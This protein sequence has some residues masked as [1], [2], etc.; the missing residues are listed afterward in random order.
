MDNLTLWRMCDELTVIQAARL[1]HGLHPTVS[2]GG[3]EDWS[4]AMIALVNAIRGGRLPATIRYSSHQ[5][6]YSEK[7]FQKQT[8]WQDQARLACVIPPDHPAY[9]L[10]EQD[11]SRSDVLQLNLHDAEYIIYYPQPDWDQTTVL[12]SDLKQWL[13]NSGARPE[14]FFPD[15]DQ[16]KPISELNNLNP[17]LSDNSLDI[18]TQENKYS[19]QF[20]PFPIP[21]DTN[22]EDVIIRFR[23]GHTVSIKVKSETR[24]ANF[25]QMGMVNRRNGNPTVQWKLFNVFAKNLGVLNW[26]SKEA[27]L[28]NQKRCEKLT[29]NL[30][31]YFGIREKPFRLT[32]NKKGW[33]ARFVISIDP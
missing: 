20:D 17:Q 2:S 5:I 16:G 27:D 19:T 7:L 26:S 14:F 25:T 3:E 15:S 29:H 8:H 1:I 10:A 11:S 23:D 30:Q 12:V 22:W 31:T 28:K 6:G 9:N 4:I 21:P 33:K 24:V 32:D 18:R 13:V